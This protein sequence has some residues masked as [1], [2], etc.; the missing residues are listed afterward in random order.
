M[1]PS[2]SQP[3]VSALKS[4]YQAW[5]ARIAKLRSCDVLDDG[6][7]PFDPRLDHRCESLCMIAASCAELKKEACDQA[8]AASLEACFDK[9]EEDVATC[10]DGEKVSAHAVCDL[11]KDCGDGEDEKHCETFTCADGSHVAVTSRCDAEP[12]CTDE[13]D[14]QGCALICGRP[15]VEI[16]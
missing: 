11:A 14:E 9:C 4:D 15:R 10:A 3:D 5:E 12:D 16:Q 1:Q 8:A 7:L 2:A 6:A 13:S